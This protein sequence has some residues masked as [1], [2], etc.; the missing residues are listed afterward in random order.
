M[1]NCLFSFQARAGRGIPRGRGVGPPTPRGRVP[2]PPPLGRG[3]RGVSRGIPPG[4]IPVHLHGA[5][6]RGSMVGKRKF[7]TPSHQ[8]QGDSKR[9][10]QNSGA[11]QWGSHPIPQQPLNSTGYNG[12]RNRTTGNPTHWYQDSYGQQWG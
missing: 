4:P 3:T 1:I 11:G 10:F 9:R 6:P 12:Y 7:D 5:L 8:N 2:V